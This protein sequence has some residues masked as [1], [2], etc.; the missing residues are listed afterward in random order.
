MAISS[1]GKIVKNNKRTKTEKGPLSPQKSKCCSQVEQDEEQD[2]PNTPPENKPEKR[3][4]QGI[5]IDGITYTCAACRAGHRVGVCKHAKERP[6]RATHPPGRPA[7]G[8]TKKI[9][10]D[11]PKNCS[12]AR[13]GC[14]CPR[15]CSCTQD[16]YL[17]VYVP[18]AQEP[19]NSQADEESG[20]WKLGK[21]V[22]TDLKGNLLTA[23][24]VEKRQQQKL[25]QKAEKESAKTFP[26]TP[27]IPEGQILLQSST[28][29][30]EPK[31]CCKA[32]QPSE[33]PPQDTAPLAQ[34]MTAP[35]RP[36]STQGCFCG[37]N[38]SCAFCPSHPNNH[39]SQN[40]ARQQALLFSQQQQHSD[41]NQFMHT[42]HNLQTPQIN[43]CMGQQPMFAMSHL[44]MRPTPAS[45]QQ[46]FPLAAPGYML[47]YPMRGHFGRSISQTPMGPP[48][49]VF[50]MNT[51]QS[52]PSL[53]TSSSI[54]SSMDFDDMC[55]DIGDAFV[56][57]DGPDGWHQLSNEHDASVNFPSISPP[58]TF[59]PAAWNMNMDLCMPTPT[60]LDLSSPPIL[61]QVEPNFLD[62]TP[63]MSIAPV[64]NPPCPS[65]S[66]RTPAPTAP[67]RT[68]ND[69]SQLYVSPGAYLSPPAQIRSSHG[70]VDDAWRLQAL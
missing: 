10:C 16:M 41:S 64:T 29:K 46:A 26:I 69:I 47:A 42:L 31:H 43:S 50:N 39:T 21:Q 28:P 68:A 19:D 55:F 32:S 53:Q 44:P 20:S 6:M 66:N 56:A 17:L 54:E 36:A 63:G 38:C 25:A 67:M 33:P 34:T 52:T 37:T 18:G 7:S 60:S 3:R 49:E 12:C 70:I 11:C 65:C 57:S 40:L 51:A 58:S 48:I 14:R 2:E 27:A 59:D 8:A 62:P 35:P 23:E 45:F 30:A 22:I 24:E 1:T 13:K 5:V 4:L 9:V 15:N 61:A